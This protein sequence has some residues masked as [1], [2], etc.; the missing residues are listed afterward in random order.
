MDLGILVSNIEAS[1]HFY[2]KLLGLKFIETMPLWFGT[3]HRLR[4]GNSD[5]KLVDP[6]TKPP[7]GPVGLESQ[8]GFRYITFVIKGLSALCRELR[9]KGVEFVLPEKEIRPGSR[10]AMVKDP[11]GNIVEF[12]ER[13]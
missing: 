11:D 3:M 10:I 4:F 8:L 1:L 2:Q 9:D 12:V 7:K 6:S 13:S 5:L